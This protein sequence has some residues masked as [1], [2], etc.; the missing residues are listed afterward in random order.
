MVKHL[1]ASFALCFSLTASADDIPDPMA[2][3][4]D[5]SDSAWQDQPTLI[6]HLT[7]RSSTAAK[8]KRWDRTMQ[9][10][11]ELG[12]MQYVPS[13]TADFIKRLNP[14]EDISDLPPEALLDPALLQLILLDRGSKVT[15]Q[16]S[17]K[18]TFKT[19][20]TWPITAADRKTAPSVLNW[21]S[22]NLGYD[23][24]V[25][26]ARDGLIL[27]GLLKSTSELGQG[28]LVKDSSKRWLIKE[29]NTRGEAL[30]QML[31][32]SGSLAV[33]EVLLA[34][35]ETLAVN[36]GS[37]ILLGQNNNWMKLLQPAPKAAARPKAL[38]PDPEPAAATQSTP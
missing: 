9:E 12:F 36:K 35:G 3:W 37:K 38:T 18:R 14:V 17:H 23:A 29:S 27:A 26:D 15:I 8:A 28:L 7:I 19:L 16:G 21:L 6:R 5:L 11:S 33:F 13:E 20:A 30:L 31:K 10:F 4:Q 32:T 34:K 22:R 25:I 2:W 24:V 1:I